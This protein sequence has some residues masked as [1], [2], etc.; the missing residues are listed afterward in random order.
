M[1]EEY[2]AAA[3]VALPEADALRAARAAAAAWGADAR[4]AMAR[5]D[6]AARADALQV[7]GGRAA[8][9][10]QRLS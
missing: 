7:R 9:R 10:A 8:R 6:A 3:V 1:L 5:A 4:A 2:D